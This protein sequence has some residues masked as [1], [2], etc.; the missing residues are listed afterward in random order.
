[1]NASFACSQSRYSCSKLPADNHRWVERWIVRRSTSLTP[2]TPFGSLSTEA[3]PTPTV[4]P[5]R[6]TRTFLARTDGEFT[7]HV[8]DARLCRGLCY[9]RADRPTS[10]RLHV[11]KP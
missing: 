6:K 10:F 8:I 9:F 3:E 11:E 7:R 2:P 1:M 5:D 4:Q